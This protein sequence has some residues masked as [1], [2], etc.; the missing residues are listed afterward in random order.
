MPD[1]EISLKTCYLILLGNMPSKPIDYSKTHFY[2]IVCKDTS[3]TDC[4]VGH[5]TDFTKRKNHHKANCYNQNSKNFS[6]Y[7]YHFFRENGGWNNFDMVVI[8]IQKCESSLEA[9]KI[10]REHIEELQATLNRY[11]PYKTEEEKQKR[12]TSGTSNII[13]TTRKSGKIKISSGMRTIK[14]KRKNKEKN[15]MKTIKTQSLN[16]TRNGEMNIKKNNKNTLKTIVKRTRTRLKRGQVKSYNVNVVSL[17]PDI[18]NQDIS[19]LNDIKHILIN[20]MKIR[21]CEINYLN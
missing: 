20:K 21:H 7:V 19:K 16:K 11:V 3:I 4:Y 13:K 17:T 6:N 5:T 8:N 18:I 10:E 1:F 15:D 14:I 2:K 12:R 9:R